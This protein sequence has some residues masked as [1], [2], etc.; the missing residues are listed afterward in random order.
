MLAIH[1]GAA[2]TRRGLGTNLYH[3]GVPSKV[4][5]AILRH[6]NVSVTEGYYITPLGDDF[7]SA[8]AES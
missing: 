7:K 1:S 4:I 5:Q 8:M 2:G 3:L 6:S